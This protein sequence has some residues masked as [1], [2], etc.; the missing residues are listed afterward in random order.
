MPCTSEPLRLG[1]LNI[2]STVSFFPAVVD[3]APAP[4][5]EYA[6]AAIAMQDEEPL[7]CS[8][9][10]WL[11]RSRRRRDIL[12]CVGDGRNREQKLRVESYGTISGGAKENAGW[13]TGVE[14]CTSASLL[15]RGI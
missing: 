7:R 5:A 8:N 4:A 1:A 11:V 13:K 9:H 15:Q 14:R 6:V 12:S 3:V 10:A 2:R